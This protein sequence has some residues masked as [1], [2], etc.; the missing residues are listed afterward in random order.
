[1]VTAIGATQANVSR[2][3]QTLARSGILAR[4]KEGL[5]VHYRIVDE[6][7]PELCEMVC[8]SLREWSHERARSA[9]VSVHESASK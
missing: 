1:M 6:T 2:H 4:R 5:C 9:G 3:L 8:G 7:I